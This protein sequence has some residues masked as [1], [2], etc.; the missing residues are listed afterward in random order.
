MKN[1]SPIK[2]PIANCC[3]SFIVLFLL[4]YLSQETSIL[5]THVPQA[6]AQMNQE[7]LARI[8]TLLE[9]QTEDPVAGKTQG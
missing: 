8:L 1:N 4:V 3:V 7:Q 6:L 9:R 2:D 5:S